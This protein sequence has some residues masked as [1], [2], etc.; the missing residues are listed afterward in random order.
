M[1][2]YVPYVQT[3]SAGV[4]NQGIGSLHLY[5]SMLQQNGLELYNEQ[6]NATA[7]NKVEAIQVFEEWTEMYTD[8]GYL[9]EAD[10]YNRFR[11]GSMPLGIASYTTYMTI[12]S[13][14]PEIDGRWTI[15]NVPGTYNQETGEIDHTIAGAGSGC[16]IL[17]ASPHRD[18]A[19]EFL[20]W[21]TEAET[22]SRYSNNV[23]SILG[24]L[25]RVAT[26]NVEAFN[27]LAWD[28]DDL[29]KL[30]EQW[31][32]VKELPELPG[33]YYTIRAVDQAFWSVIND[34]VNP[35][36]AVKKWSKIAD[37]E[38]ERKIKQYS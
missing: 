30:N 14:A 36:D 9:K 16:S 5:P 11:N 19:W 31:S 25:G 10:F 32:K 22:Q 29:A 38:I 13:A 21:W 20:K 15:A 7:I 37:N 6:K 24:M 2:V 3:T 34:N 23:E 28:P 1:N 26:A 17:K 35:K 18:A 27:T 33:S 4:V 8:Y 12:Y